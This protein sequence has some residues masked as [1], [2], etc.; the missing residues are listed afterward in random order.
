MIGPCLRFSPNYPGT[1]KLPLPAQRHSISLL[2]AASFLRR[3]RIFA[4]GFT[5][6]EN[7]KRM[8]STAVMSSFGSL[9]SYLSKKCAITSL[10]VL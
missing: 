3:I 10:V 6:V 1:D 9:N 4:L 8:G 2:Q 7:P 5:N